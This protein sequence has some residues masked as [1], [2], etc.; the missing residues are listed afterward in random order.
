[1]GSR[2]LNAS[3]NNLPPT[4]TISGTDPPVRLRMN[5]T[6]HDHIDSVKLSYLIVRSLEN[7]VRYPGGSPIPDQGMLFKWLNADILVK[8]YPPG[9]AYLTYQTTAAVLR[10][11]WELSI[12]YAPCSLDMEV[13]VGG[14]DE[15]HHRGHITL[16]LA[17]EPRETS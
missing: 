15:V 4:Y 6:R 16:Y 10:G 8:S 11:I 5:P 3:N 13:Y 2:L 12:L 17:P 1:M 7:L 14:L 9:T